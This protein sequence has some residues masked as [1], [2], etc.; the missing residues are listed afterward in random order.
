MFASMDGGR[1]GYMAITPH[2]QAPRHVS[3]PPILGNNLVSH[4]KNGSGWPSSAEAPARMDGSV[5]EYM[6]NLPSTSRWA[7]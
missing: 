1:P 7:S 4:S 2:I 6:A 3:P 5:P